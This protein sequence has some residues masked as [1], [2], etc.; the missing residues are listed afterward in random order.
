MSFSFGFFDDADASSDTT[1]TAAGN[2]AAKSW[3]SCAD[4]DSWLPAQNV[5]EDAVAAFEASH[6]NVDPENSV[7]RWHSFVVSDSL[8]L[9]AMQ[10]ASEAQAHHTDV[11]PG[12]YEGGLK[13]WE[14]TLDLLRFLDANSTTFC[15]LGTQV[16]DLGCGQGLLGC[17]ALQKGCQVDFQ[18]LN[19]EVLVKQT[20]PNAVRNTG[21]SAQE[22]Y[23]SGRAKLFAGDWRSYLASQDSSIELGQADLVVSS[24]TLYSDSLYPALYDLLLQ[25]LRPGKESVALLAAKRFYF[26]VGGGTDTFALYCQQRGTLLCE[27]VHAVSDGNSNVRDIL[28]VSRA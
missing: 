13:L 14:C 25:V 26:G 2:D 5:T 11:D 16:L 1:I 22:L 19:R 7:R 12:K 27:R 10:D 4:A 9:E 28:K 18:D 20:L 23:G 21:L 15:Q 24:E 17:W 6:N 3:A 8:R